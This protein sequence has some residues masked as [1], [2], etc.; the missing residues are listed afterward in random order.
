MSYSIFYSGYEIKNASQETVNKLGAAIE[1]SLT[2]NAP[3][4]FRTE[5]IV[6]ME[7]GTTTIYSFVVGP[8]IPILFRTTN[9]APREAI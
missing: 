6:D 4:L 2:A 1:A 7:T 5:H 9:E 3:A 8:G